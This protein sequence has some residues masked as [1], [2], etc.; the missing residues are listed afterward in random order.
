MDLLTGID[1]KGIIRPLDKAAPPRT[2][3]QRIPVLLPVLLQLHVRAEQLARDESEQ[4]RNC[5]R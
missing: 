2:K 5:K 3:E 1:R 4:F